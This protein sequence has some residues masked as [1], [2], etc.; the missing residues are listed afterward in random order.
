MGGISD[1]KLSHDN[2]Y[3]LLIARKEKVCGKIT[4][5]SSSLPHVLAFLLHYYSETPLAITDTIGTQH[6][7]HYSEVSLTQ[8]LPVI[9]P[10][11]R[12]PPVEYNVAAFSELSFAVRWQGRLKATTVNYSSDGGPIL[13]KKVNECPLNRGR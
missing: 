12:N 5:H 1:A 2:Q 3:I 7:V 4:H 11:L 13:L 9:F 10:V 8:G 6:F